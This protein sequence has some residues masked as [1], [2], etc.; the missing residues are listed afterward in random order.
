LEA[1][2]DRLDDLVASRQRPDPI[3]GTPKRSALMR[4]AARRPTLWRAF[5][6][7]DT[8]RTT[9][10]TAANRP[11]H[12]RVASDLPPTDRDDAESTRQ[13]ATH[14][15][16]ATSGPTDHARAPRRK[17]PRCSTQPGIVDWSTWSR[18]NA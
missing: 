8:V 6:A 12:R 13:R 18:T 7:S 17:A 4:S 10:A 15:T 14:G 16:A 1:W 11:S 5:A 2:L 9:I 3:Q